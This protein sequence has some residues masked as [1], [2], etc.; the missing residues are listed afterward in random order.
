MQKGSLLIQI[1]NIIGI[2]L[3]LLSICW[4]EIWEKPHVC[5]PEFQFRA[6]VTASFLPNKNLWQSTD[7][8]YLNALHDSQVYFWSLIN[9]LTELMLISSS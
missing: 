6:I 3:A 7:T 9:F 2:Q 4:S 5:D 8:G 1:L